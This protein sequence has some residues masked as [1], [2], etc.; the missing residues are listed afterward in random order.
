[1]GEALVN[2]CSSLTEH[3]DCSLTVRASWLEGKK[4]FFSSRVML[5]FG[6]SP[7]QITVST[8]IE[9]LQDEIEAMG[10]SRGWWWSG[11]SVGRGGCASGA[12][13]FLAMQKKVFLP[14][15]NAAKRLLNDHRVSLR[16]A[17]SEAAGSN[18]GG[19][20]GGKLTGKEL[21][22]GGKIVGSQ[23][24]AKLRGWREENALLFQMGP[25][26][27]GLGKRVQW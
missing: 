16:C 1:M 17:S 7:F 15:S 23:Q 21:E 5:N 27:E 4:L 3:Q 13:C 14:E 12:I 10:Q 9:R 20:R 19:G 6:A 8:V 26:N 24:D 2:S 11:V 25:C 22:F 18:Q